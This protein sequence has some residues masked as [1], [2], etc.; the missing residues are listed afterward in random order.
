MR[1][2]LEEMTEE[3]FEAVLDNLARPD[4]GEFTDEEFFGA[5]AAMEASEPTERIELIGTV[6]ADG[7][8]FEPTDGVRVRG[9]EIWVGDKCLIVTLRRKVGSDR[10]KQA[11][12]TAC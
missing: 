12:H 8:I 4:Y 6:T 3:E 9:N 11:Y 5:L 1:K 10:R 7:V 2:K